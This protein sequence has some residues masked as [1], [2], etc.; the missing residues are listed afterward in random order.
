MPKTVN[1]PNGRRLQFPDEASEDQILGVLTN[2][3]PEFSKPSNDVGAPQR[4]PGISPP[5]EPSQPG[6]PLL[7]PPGQENAPLVTPS[8]E[9]APQIVRSPERQAQYDTLEAQ[10]QALRDAAAGITPF[11]GFKQ[12]M[13]ERLSE[14]ARGG[15]Q[16]VSGFS[17]SLAEFADYMDRNVLDLTAGDP[18]LQERALYKLGN[19]IDELGKKLPA[20]DQQDFFHDVARA[21]GQMGGM[22]LGGLGAKA[23]KMS[24]SAAAVTA[25]LGLE[26]D[27]AYQS[28]IERGDDP[29]KAFKKSLLYSIVAGA[30]ESKLGAG[31]I[32]R[33][34]FPTAK[35]AVKKLTALGVSKNIIGN[36]IAGFGEE[37]SQRFAQNWIVEEAPSMEGVAREGLVGSVVQ[38][39]V[40]L[41]TAA[42]QPPLSKEEAQKK[43]DDF[44][45]QAMVENPELAQALIDTTAQQKGKTDALEP[46]P[47]PPVRPVRPEAKQG[48]EGKV[49]AEEAG[50]KD[51]EGGSEEVGKKPLFKELR[52]LNTGKVDIGSLS[53]DQIKTL[54]EAS[55]VTIGRLDLETPRK[56]A[57]NRLQEL[58][59]R[60]LLSYDSITQ[61]SKKEPGTPTT[62][63]S[64]G[65]RAS[66]KTDKFL[67]KNSTHVLEDDGGKVAINIPEEGPINVD[68]INA[69]ERRKG[70]GSKLINKV[71]EMA[72]AMNRPVT[73]TSTAVGNMTQEGLNAFYEKNG[74]TATGRKDEHGY[75]EFRYEPVN[76]EKPQKPPAKEAPPKVVPV[77]TSE[78]PP[79][80]LKGDK[81]VEE[82]PS[83]PEIPKQTIRTAVL[84]N[85]NE[86]PSVS[87]IRKA[88]EKA[89]KDLAAYQEYFENNADGDQETLDEYTEVR[90]SLIA[91]L[92]KEEQKAAPKAKTSEPP[93][94]F[95]PPQRTV[96]KPTRNASKKQIVEDGKKWMAQRKIDTQK[97]KDWEKALPPNERLVFEDGTHIHAVTK[98]PSGKWR[99]T[100]FDKKDHAPTSHSVFNTRLEAIESVADKKRIPKIP[101]EVTPLEDKAPTASEKPQVPA[102]PSRDDNQK[103][104]SDFIA[105]AMQRHADEELAREILDML[106]LGDEDVRDLVRQFYDKTW[107]NLSEANQKKFTKMIEAS[108]GLKLG[109]VIGVEKDGTK[110]IG[111]TVMDLLPPDYFAKEAS[112]LEGIDRGLIALMWTANNAV[113]MKQAD[114]SP[115]PKQIQGKKPDSV[116][117]LINGDAWTPKL[118]ALARRLVKGEN[119]RI[120]RDDF[121]SEQEWKNALRLTDQQWIEDLK[122]FANQDPE[123]IPEAPSLRGKWKK[124]LIVQITDAQLKRNGWKWGAQVI[125]EDDTSAGFAGYHATEEGA[126]ENAKKAWAEWHPGQPIPREFSFSDFPVI[127][128]GTSV[129]D[130]L[131]T[132][133]GVLQREVG[134]DGTIENGELVTP[135]MKKDV[136]ESVWPILENY[137]LVWNNT[138]KPAGRNGRKYFFGIPKLKAQIELDKLEAFLQDGLIPE[139][140]I[141]KAKARIEEL[142]KELGS[143]PKETTKIEGV[144]PESQEAVD[145]EAETPPAVKQSE[146]F[147]VKA[148]KAQ[149]KFLVSELSQAEKEATDKL[150]HPWTPAPDVETAE[151]M[152]KRLADNKKAWEKNK[153]DFGTI[154]IEI[155]GDGTWEVINTKESIQVAANYAKKWPV[156]KWAPPKP[157]GNVTEK[158]TPKPALSKPKN[159]AEAE[160]ALKDIV[161][162]DKNRDVL[163]HVA[164][165]GTELVA[166]NGRILGIIKMKGPGTP[167]K[168]ALIKGGK[169][170]QLKEDFPNFREIIP[171]EVLVVAKDINV[172]RVLSAITQAEFMTSDKSNSMLVV[173][174][175]DGSLGFSS[176]S[177]EFGSF[178]TNVQDGH[179]KLAAFSPVLLKNAVTLMKRSGNESFS[180]ALT[181]SG[182]LG[183]FVFESPGALSVLMPMRLS[184][185]T[186]KTTIAAEE[187]AEK[188]YMGVVKEIT[189]NNFR[190]PEMK[191]PKPANKPT[192]KKKGG[193]ESE[194]ER[195]H[196][197][198][199]KE[200]VPLTLEVQDPLAPTTESGDPITMD[201][202]R[203]VATMPASQLLE[204]GSFN[205]WT[206]PF[207]FKATLEQ[208][209]ELPALNK[210]LRER[211]QKAKRLYEKMF[212]KFKDQDKIPKAIASEFEA[213]G[214]AVQFYSEILD[215][216]TGKL[217]KVI[218]EKMIPNYE[219]RFTMEEIEE[220]GDVS[221]SDRMPSQR[222]NIWAMSE[223]ELDELFGISEDEVEKAR[224]GQ[225]E[226]D[227]FDDFVKY[228]DARYEE[229]DLEGMLLA[230]KDANGDFKKRYIL[231]NR[232]N[233]DHKKAWISHLVTLSPLPL[234]D[235]PQ[236]R[237]TPRPTARGVERPRPT[238]TETGG[239]PK[240][241]EPA[242]PTSDEDSPYQAISW[243]ALVQFLK[244][245]GRYPEIN[246]RMKG[247]VGEYVHRHPSLAKEVSTM[248]TWDA[249]R[250][251]RWLKSKDEWFAKRVLAHEIG[252]FID[253]GVAGPGNKEDFSGKFNT[254]KNWIPF[255]DPKFRGTDDQL[256]DD[257]KR[258]SVKMR[259]PFDFVRDDYRNKPNELFADFMSAMF[260]NPDMVSREFPRLHQKF[261]DLMANKPELRG[262]WEY[263]QE[264]VTGKK[265]MAKVRENIDEAAKKTAAKILERDKKKKGGALDFLKGGFIT[266]W[267][268]AIGIEGKLRVI[269]DSL[270]DLLE[271]SSTWAILQDTLSQDTFKKTVD[272][273]LAKVDP[274][275]EKARLLLNQ[276]NQANRTIGERRAAGVWIEENP[277][278]ARELLE[279]IVATHPDLASAYSNRVANSAPSQMY[280]LAG[281]IFADVHGIGEDFAKSIAQLIDSLDVDI[282]GQAALM[283]FNVRGKLLNPEGV[284]EA[285]AQDMIRTLQRELGPVKYAALEK[286]AGNM[287]DI[288]FQTQ[289]K[290]WKEG[291]IADEIWSE[292]ILPNK[293]NYV[294]YAV[295]D[296]FDGR[297]RAGVIPQA[298]TAK[299]VADTIL[300]SQLKQASLNAWRQHQYQV[301]LLR[302]M[303][304]KGG[305][306]VVKIGK[307]LKRAS[308]IQ[309]VRNENLDDSI[310]RS[311][312][313]QNGK[314]FVIEFHDDI[315]KT[316]E[317][318]LDSKSLAEHMD[319]LS[320]LSAG[321]HFV[322]Q[323][324]TTLSLSFLLFR[325]LVRGVQTNT[326]RLGIRNAIRTYS[327][328]TI[329]QSFYD[330]RNYAKAAYGGEMS[331]FIREL[332]EAEALTVPRLSASMIRDFANLED[333]IAKGVAMGSYARR[334]DAKKKR[335]NLANN[336]RL[337]VEKMNRAFTVLE[338]MEKIQAYKMA[339]NDA[340]GKFSK[341]E[342]SAMARRAGIPKPGVG[343]HWSIPMEIFM[344]WTR[345]HLQGTRVDWELIRDPKKR[346]GFLTRF[347]AIELAPR[348]FK[349]AVAVG[350]I[351]GVLSQIL[352]D[353][354]D[355][356]D[357]VMAEVYKRI[358]PYKMALDNTV[359]LALYDPRTGDR[360]FFWDFKSGSEIPKHYEVMSFRIP[361]SE[362]GRLWGT[363]FYNMLTTLGPE[364]AERAGATFPNEAYRW[365]KD[366]FLPG[367]SPVIETA[368]ATTSMVGGK[369]P[370]NTYTGGPAA[371]KQ[372]YDAGW[373]E[374]RGQAILGYLLD[375]AGGWGQ[376][377]ATAGVISGAFDPRMR[378]QVKKR[379]SDDK[380]PLTD[381]F[382]L[383]R[384]A[385]SYDNYSGYREE[386][387][388]DV[389]E[390][391]LRAKSKM[392][393]T[394]DVQDLY[395]FYWRNN[396]RKGNLDAA[397]YG[398]L[399]AAREFVT[400]VWG[401]LD[402]PDSF[403]N[404]AAYAVN[405]GSKENR[406]TVMESLDHAAEPYIA[407]FKDPDAARFN[408]ILHVGGTETMKA[409]MDAVSHQKYTK[410]LDEEYGKMQDRLTSNPKWD[411]LN[412]EEKKEL[413]LEG[414]QIARERAA[415]L[416]LQTTTPSR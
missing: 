273:E 340:S 169:V 384:S 248:P 132:F 272:P 404:K 335:S 401:K 373:G 174:N 368:Q 247:A 217:N 43:M 105:A 141:E 38:G 131:E 12:E 110:R 334:I 234:E 2:D 130:A 61:E 149:K 145:E 258:L 351:K 391:M 275:I 7:P 390:E 302:K 107:N 359:P 187:L 92:N 271:T 379:L 317:Q 196:E 345:V 31:R 278:E 68:F 170:V 115:A 293:G 299:E 114:A 213:V 127:E 14:V 323:L 288:F 51:D 231:Q 152:K 41:P 260:I 11:T 112:F 197:K 199:R 320:K 283:A 106:E 216:V 388:A 354:E 93:V 86:N 239:P 407:T 331:P 284:D 349:Y 182:E 59:D 250:L 66:T 233:S 265:L 32:M 36:F 350:V 175:K 218:R 90:D 146:P 177:E 53:D 241:D 109:E 89:E 375:Q 160:K 287:R 252:H 346:G 72:D 70:Q 153:E 352:G 305:S 318:A 95:Q 257:A 220:E 94:S 410:I 312:I 88:L 56:S 370:E 167:E 13:A 50:P 188:K 274:D 40:S 360:H 221:E 413:R 21:G 138:M 22:L 325:N 276:F 253:I 315:G 58:E 158:P 230:F 184:G 34:F 181:E 136:W 26:F 415:S 337:M 380:T 405:E 35:D 366:Y 261:Y 383:S 123:S 282:K 8:L 259:G 150:P 155:P 243:T 143:K 327:P 341:V 316:I 374:G 134:K 116:E 203:S 81:V 198:G 408:A 78:K 192:K 400:K 238:S 269:G 206:Y 45:N 310:S 91:L 64:F 330:A 5:G 30:I 163:T 267:H 96:F 193:V 55:G 348:A 336:Y 101:F 87:R 406:R 16:N 99:V 97:M 180:M 321:T 3:Y 162:T 281:E 362:E 300:T 151:A 255:F 385:I 237:T 173:L 139:N 202:I 314:P 279:T 344:P 245:F 156:S 27:D 367:L 77:S 103:K 161:S 6:K 292:I 353:D 62:P 179:L 308:D 128:R 183:V 223:A 1:L 414:R 304:E 207:A 171:S 289:K 270:K 124:V 291:L 113:E 333:M 71:K 172:D 191:I 361:S 159:A 63:E 219:A 28:S 229:R 73:L 307:K 347:A 19:K 133:N 357:T 204:L 17:R 185:P 47:T 313:Y 338:A 369:N 303:Y 343:G 189:G 256:L 129:E 164:S 215:V 186:T 69:S 201:F 119:V 18:K 122:A 266:K 244:W 254:L 118:E 24:T 286:A 386:K 399:Q 10:K 232:K 235:P 329:S 224:M 290:A 395:N 54:A 246:K 222:P 324:Y 251:W 328:S 363:L 411:L 46:K 67:H 210:A 102:K 397:D 309:Q 264:L 142:K 285:F 25:G 176:W 297:V 322:M 242:P 166:T 365:M 236:P 37:A 268:R 195:A 144:S 393:M 23:L 392:V 339:I 80:E 44:L 98:D 214:S 319:F 205:K 394:Q 126:M 263:I 364:G 342:A 75:P 125:L 57:L 396:T 20:S 277:E 194:K 85:G 226:F 371:N 356:D 65:F 111:K 409:R 294:P 79:L 403:Y 332:V 295:L 381:W 15:L 168:P 412:D 311:V 49:P 416:F 200:G 29:D 157:K 326:V 211:Y 52:R 154:L 355:P 120:T 39:T 389:K 83:A 74:F 228:M 42:I 48:E 9:S 82:S 84:F 387:G 117:S 306:S 165:T 178:E 4:P 377:V 398:R 298:G 301:T 296:Y 358:S 212:M 209:A 227:K 121:D 378:D 148:A 108:S 135:A 372:L 104:L 60:G 76:K 137:G 208:L 190:S 280:D 33:K 402:N 382:A 225:Y 376:M 240:P 262:A 147:N 100:R 249:I 140:D